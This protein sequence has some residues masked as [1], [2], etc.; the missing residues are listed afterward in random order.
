MKKYKIFVD[1]NPAE[2]RRVLSTLFKFGYVFTSNR[3]RTI[4]EVQN[5]W[6]GE[7]MIYWD[8]IVIGHNE[9]CKATL[10][11]IRGDDSSLQ[12]ITLED[13]LKLK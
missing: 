6:G 4:N 7:R 3:V 12:Q 5:L 9:D 1:G 8:W 10:G 11:V 13:F 2:I